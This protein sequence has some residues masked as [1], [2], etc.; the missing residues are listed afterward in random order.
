M[1][2]AKYRDSCKK[3]ALEGPNLVSMAI[4]VGY[5]PEVLF[6][7]EAYLQEKSCM[8]INELPTAVKKVVMEES[9]FKKNI[10]ETTSPQNVA[11]I[12]SYEKK[13][14]DYDEPVTG[15]LAIILDRI[16]DPGNM[17]ALIRTATAA[18]VDRIYYSKGCADP[19]SPKVL[20]STAGSIFLASTIYYS[21]S[22][23]LISHLKSNLFKLVATTPKTNKTFWNESYIGKIAIVIGN[24]AAGVSDTLMDSVDSCVS[25][26]VRK[27]VE[28]LNASV[29][30]AIMLYEILRQRYRVDGQF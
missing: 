30:G 25:I 12:I 13:L 24:E 29:S 8:T 20:R 3:L 26:P 2:S 6:F 22:Q 10:A 28:S 18:G 1:R 7:T 11:A 4:N 9:F 27:P 16:Q 19:Y 21:D 15:D 23:K 17:G 5:I 14:F